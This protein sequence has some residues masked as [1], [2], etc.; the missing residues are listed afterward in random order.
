MNRLFVVPALA[1]PVRD[2]LKAGLQTKGMVLLALIKFPDILPP[3]K[4]TSCFLFL[5]SAARLMAVEAWWPQFRGP[6]CSGVSETAH[7][8]AVFAPGTNQLWKVAVPSGMSSPVIWGDRIFLTAFNEGKLE[9]RCHARHDGQ[10]LWQRV[11]PATQ[12]EEF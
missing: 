10:L 12:L 3:M 8:P 2:S 1:G 7:P 4:L 11:I 5:L 6:N 9:V